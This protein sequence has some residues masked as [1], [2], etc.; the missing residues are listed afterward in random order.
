MNPAK[1]I[2]CRC[3]QFAFRMSIPLMPYRKPRIFSAFGE[4]VTELKSLGVTSLL[5]VTDSFL[6]K[7]GV[8][9]GLPCCRNQGLLVMCMTGQSQ[10]PRCRT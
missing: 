5:L 1:K 4:C 9:A 2:Y 8:T 6:R 7:S 10:I 3:F